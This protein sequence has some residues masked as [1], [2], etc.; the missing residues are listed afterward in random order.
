M[1]F[2]NIKSFI[3]G[4]VVGAVGITSVF[5][6]GVIQS[7]TYNN[8][9][10][11][12]NGNTLNITNPLVSI[13]KQGETTAQTYMPV[14]EILQ[15]LGYSVQWYENSKTIDIITPAINSYNINSDIKNVVINL[16]NQNTFNMSES[17]NFYAKD[18]D[19]LKLQIK[20]ELINGSVDFIL[21]DP[22]GVQRKTITIDKMDEEIIIELS[23]GQWAY[24]CSGM[25]RGGGNLILIGTLE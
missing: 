6:S 24:N 9:N 20:A 15:I 13:V 5:A 4:L 3:S 25:F 1:K 7:A 2:S 14:R 11:T 17:G 8:Y 23:K 10:I 22:N 21:F 16:K 19:K 18:G 12:L